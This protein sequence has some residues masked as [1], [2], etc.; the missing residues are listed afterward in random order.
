M[1]NKYCPYCYS[2]IIG[3]GYEEFE[4]SIGFD[5]VKYFICCANCGSRGPISDT[6]KGAWNKF[7]NRLMSDNHIKYKIS[8]T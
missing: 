5:E 4:N 8:K 2:D 6:S 3:I 7:N 1:E